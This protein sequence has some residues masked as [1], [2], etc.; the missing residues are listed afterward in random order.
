MLFE[1]AK[2]NTPDSIISEKLQA[3]ESLLN[4]VLKIKQKGV[5]NRSLRISLCSQRLAA[6]SNNKKP[7]LKSPPKTNEIENEH[8]GLNAALFI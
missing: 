8:I 7:F 6:K 4:G 5:K 3:I 1:A 2:T